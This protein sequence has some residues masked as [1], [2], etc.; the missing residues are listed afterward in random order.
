VQ[1][2]HRRF[3]DTLFIGPAGV[4]KSS[5]ARAVAQRLMAEE[6]IFFSGSDVPRPSALIDKLHEKGKLPRAQ[7]GKVCIHRCLIFIDEVHALARPT[8]IAML[9]AMDDAR[10][11]TVGGT[12][13]DFGDVVF[14]A[15][16]TD[17]GLLSDAFVSRMDIIP[18]SAYS[19]EELAGIIWHHGKRL[20]KGFELPREVCI[21][22]AARNRCNPRRAVRSLENDLLAEFYSH[23][24]VQEH[25]Q[26]DAEQAAAKLMTKEAV[27]EYYESHGVDLNGL[28]AFAHNAL[29]YL[30]Q[31]GPT[32]EDRLSRGL[33]ISNR[34]DFVELIEYLSRLG[35]VT[36]DHTGRNLT[37]IGRRYLSKPED[38]RSRI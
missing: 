26:R 34:A 19:L 32:P 38:L 3:S 37:S 8:S 9:S 31:H 11:A 27:A 2:T 24:S 5:L 33:R 15:A 36:T 16:T 7:Q 14:I 1:G 21:E 22:V 30:K 29:S 28:D 12:E 10:I 23:L 17:K 20:F 35:L 13:Y 6:P 25:E 4:G 18:L